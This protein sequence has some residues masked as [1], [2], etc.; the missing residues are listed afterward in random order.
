MSFYKKIH[1]SFFITSFIYC[2]TI[3][4][5]IGCASSPRFVSGRDKGRRTSTSS[6]DG[7]QNP[8][9]Q[10]GIAS[11]YANQ[12]DGNQTSNGETYDMYALTAAHPTLPFNTRVKVTNLDN[13]RS[14]ILRINDRGPFLKER[15]IDVSY[16]AAKQLQMIGTGTARVRVEIIEWG[17]S[18]AKVK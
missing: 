9:I 17:Q 14:V 2:S 5:L 15:I 8:A 1:L 18:D 11:Y 4:L 16:V 6:D 13:G 10:E 3:F 7:T 12:Y